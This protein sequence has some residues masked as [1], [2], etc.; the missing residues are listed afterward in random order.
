MSVSIYTRLGVLFKKAT[1]ISN[2]SIMRKNIHKKIGMLF[3]KKKYCAKDIVAAMAR[4]GM[5][6][7]DVV[8]IHASMKEFYNY[9]G[10][11]TE[12]IDTLTEYLTEEG[13]LMMPA[14]PF[15]DFH[16]VDLDNY[17]FNPATDKTAAGFLA[18]T[19]RNY[20]H[21]K[22]S[23]NTQHSVCAWGKHALWLTKD[24]HL[25]KNCWDESSPYYRMAKLNGLVI[26]LGMPSHYIG[27]FDHCVEGILYK[28][29]PYWKLF[30][31]KTQT[32]RYY[33]EDGSICQYT[34]MRGDLDCRSRERILIKHFDSD[35]HKHEK[36]SNLLINV[37]Y[38]APCLEKMLELGRRGITMYYYPSPKKY[39]F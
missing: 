28:E 11:A 23:I 4:M 13:T 25:G 14:M 39:K 3:Y 36:L 30:M 27:T 24:H 29:Y 6:P 31:N 15:T 5:K 2:I 33:S 38:A 37:Y 10:T 22:R 26:N 12:L 20:P 16:D 17:I 35:I 18:E 7:G 1:G 34:C 8:C 21:V 9:Q 32:F 19:F